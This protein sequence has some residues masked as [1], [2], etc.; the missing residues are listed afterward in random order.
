MGNIDDWMKKTVPRCQ[1]FIFFSSD[2]SL[3]SNDCI[4]EI[5]LAQKHN[6]QITPILGVNLKW[7]DLEKFNDNRELGHEFNPM[8]FEKLCK[9]ITNYALKFKEDLEKEILRKKKRR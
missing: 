7:D 2:T 1:L 5:K 9:D 6:I 4:N 8:E 3:N